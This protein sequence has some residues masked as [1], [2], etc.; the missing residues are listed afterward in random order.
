[1]INKI[2]ILKYIYNATNKEII[3][4]Y[5]NILNN[6][7]SS[8]TSE[9]YNTSNLE[10]GNDEIIELNQ[11]KK[12]L[13]TSENQNNKIKENISTIYLNQCEVLL[14]E[15]Y[16][17]TDNEK[18]YMKKIEVPQNGLN[19]SK[20]E[21]DL[22]YKSNNTKLMQMDKLICKNEKIIIYTPIIINDNNIDKYNPKSGY[23]NDP[24]YIT[25]SKDG[26]DIS[27]KDRKKDFIKDK[28]I[29]IFIGIIFINNY[30]NKI[31]N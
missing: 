26:T 23:Y 25:K 20:I 3:K 10:N 7:E 27:L 1:M 16:N 14:R 29:F 5:D 30:K 15:Y 9:N 19:I 24:C 17:I 8:F 31:I 13:T 28:K 2:C 21:Y 12:I 4:L 11:I 6:I 22:Y 18:I